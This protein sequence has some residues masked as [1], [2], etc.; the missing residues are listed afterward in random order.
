MALENLV[1]H[2]QRSMEGMDGGHFG[3]H[4]LPPMAQ[5]LELLAELARRNQ[6]EEAQPAAE[7]RGCGEAAGVA[8]LS[9]SPYLCDLR[10]DAGEA[11]NPVAGQPGSGVVLKWRIKDRVSCYNENP[12]PCCK[13]SSPPFYPTYGCLCGSLRFSSWKSSISHS[14][15]S[16]DCWER[17]QVHSCFVL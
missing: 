10:H 13:G 2:I 16:L 7:E 9:H 11:T 15:V 5:Q 1:P 8:Y 14:F 4:L 17:T 6:A 3:S 12:E